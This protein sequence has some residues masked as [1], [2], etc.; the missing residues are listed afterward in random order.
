VRVA[1]GYNR[2]E[3]EAHTQAC[4]VSAQQPGNEHLKRGQ[5]GTDCV[6]VAIKNLQFVRE[7]PAERCVYIIIT[8][9]C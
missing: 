7:T 9:L 4:G 2:A 6:L 1:G 3:V 8:G 5:S